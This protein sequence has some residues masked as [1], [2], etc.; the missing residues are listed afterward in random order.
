MHAEA[1][2]GA[3]FAA[4][5]EGMLLADEVDCRF[6]LCNPAI[7]AMLGYSE[8][9]L[10]EM[11]IHDLLPPDVHD[12]FVSQFEAMCR[13]ELDLSRDVPILR[14]DGSTLRMDVSANAVTLGNERYVMALFRD[15]SAA[16]ALRRSLE[17][18]RDV[19]R[20]ML[21]AAPV[22][23]VL[24]DRDGRVVQSNP[25]CE[26]VTGHPESVLRGRDWFELCVPSDVR[27]AVFERF[28]DAFSGNA[29]RAYENPVITRDGK[30]LSVEWHSTLLQMTDEA[31][32]L[33]LAIGLDM[34]DRTEAM[35]RLR[36]S[37][38]RLR[39]AQAVAGVGNWRLDLQTGEAEWSE[40]E[41]RLFG[42]EPGSFVP[43]REHFMRA[44]H[45]D[46]RT[47]VE[48]EL[49]SLM[50]L[51]RSVAYKL[52]HRVALAD[53]RERWVEQ[54]GNITMDASGAPHSL[55]G[56][57]LDITERRKAEQ[58]LR[59][60]NETLESRVAERTAALQESERQLRRA[61]RIGRIGHW[62]FDA[63][64]RKVEWS[65]M[66]YEMVGVSRDTFV[67]A[68]DSILELVPGTDQRLLRRAFRVL[69]V[70]GH[71]A[72][73]DLRFLTRVGEERWAHV[74][75]SADTS[76]PQVRARFTGTLQDVTD[77][78]RAELALR[79]A[80]D[81]AERASRVKSEF[82]SRMSHELRT[83][84]NSILGF[85]QV[86]ALDETLTV[87]QRDNVDEIEKA[88]R[89]LLALI[90][91]VLDLAKVEAGRVELDIEAVRCAD[92]VAE[93]VSLVTPLAA[94]SDVRLERN[95][96][97]SLVV[98]AD[99]LRLKQVL[100]NL[101]SN[102]IKYNR[103]GGVV[104]VFGSR[105]GGGERGVLSVRDTGQGISRESLSLL[106]KP[107]HRF[108]AER[109]AIEGTG[110]GLAISRRLVEMM[111]GEIDVDSEAGV[112][113]EFRILLPVASGEP[114]I[115]ARP[116]V[117]A[118]STGRA[119]DEERTTGKKEQE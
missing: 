40:Q 94:R 84:M 8:R 16:H 104:S 77:R 73:L 106:F 53:G 59:A 112:G 15:M 32:P 65:D 95:V 90:N 89:H 18:E 7:C 38:L 30:R 102:G 4:S 49:R 103:P 92:L 119:I 98:W 96:D 105:G 86:L 24:L 87:D 85:A 113:S 34:T 79:D 71:A 42:F 63:I 26:R 10:L 51:R 3:L 45:P 29:V 39:E 57:T 9:E 67:P 82:L 50:R 75:M 43:R 5:S 6:H 93:C 115:A 83:P 13:G 97:A 60:L 22:I 12:H 61:Q 99:R 14:R 76:D 21:Q 2:L 52:D 118:P 56:T 116:R 31:S 100:L 47:R 80:R 17:R 20:G 68:P 78:K 110:I 28:R 36:L 41:Y 25:W 74:E 101:L 114:S 58:R 109:G 44:V 72:S 117:E 88:G 11:C 62:T 81:E 107:F 55:F 37:E 54:R 69:V 1:L 19:T 33:M 64:S 108:D 46:D 111:N 66:I 35:R 48:A 91:E 70:R 27:P 23:V